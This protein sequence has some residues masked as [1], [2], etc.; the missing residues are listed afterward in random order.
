MMNPL[1]SKLFKKQKKKTAE[2]TLIQYFYFI[3]FIMVCLGV[4]LTYKIIFP[5]EIIIWLKNSVVLLM[6]SHFVQVIAKYR[7]L[8][9]FR[10]QY[11]V[12]GK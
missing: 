10:I 2:A 6:T 3:H 1:K 9:S 8:S 7:S 11:K 5:E 12:G 4:L